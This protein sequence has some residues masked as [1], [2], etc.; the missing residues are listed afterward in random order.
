LSSHGFV[1]KPLLEQNH[2]QS[3]QLHR[4]RQS[5]QHMLATDWATSAILTGRVS[6]PSQRNCRKTAGYQAPKKMDHHVP[7]RP[8]T[9]PRVHSGKTPAYISYATSIALP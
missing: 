2:D 8:W 4:A 5:E 6:R 1:P 7:H 3:P 9:E